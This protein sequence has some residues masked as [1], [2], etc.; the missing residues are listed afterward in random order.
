MMIEIYDADDDICQCISLSNS[1]QILLLILEHEKTKID[2]YFKRYKPK[3]STMYRIYEIY[4]QK[5]LNRTY[6]ISF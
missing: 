4:L 6:G 5:V 1:I 3:L 2:D